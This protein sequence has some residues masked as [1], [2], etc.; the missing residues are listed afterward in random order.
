MA[1]NVTIW[2]EFRHEKTDEQVKALYPEGIH[3]YLKSVLEC[4]ELNITLAALDDP[5]FGLPDEVLNNTDVLVWWAHMY[6]WDVPDELADKIRDRVFA[7]MGLILLH[8]A[9]YSKVIQRVVGMTGHLTWGD[10]VKEVVLFGASRERLAGEAKQAG[11]GGRVIVCEDLASAVRVAC[12]A[13]TDNVLFSPASSS[14]DA[15][16]GYLE[17]GR[18]FE[19][20]VGEICS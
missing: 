15:Y 17:R 13:G 7:G 19:R 10:E 6:H 1:I 2:N 16:S 4:D 14:F 3:A 12:Q 11:V 18:D 20:L 9:H 5:D 8:S